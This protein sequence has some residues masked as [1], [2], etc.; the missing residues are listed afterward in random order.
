MSW[1]S[2]FSA[3]NMWAMLAWFA[4]A[5]APRNSTTLAGVTYLGVGLLAVTYTILLIGFL[6]GTISTGG[7]G[8]GGS[9]TSLAGVMALF[10]SPGG[11]TLGWIHYLAFDLFTGL[12]IVQDG[13]SKGFNRW[14]QLPV[15]FLTF[16]VGPVGLLTWLII[17]EPAARRAAKARASRG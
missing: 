16:M 8:Q 6:T 7:G 5:F 2:L 3:A 4:L 1:E 13:A 9:F 17:R 12:W 15:L 11:T 10:A 14:L